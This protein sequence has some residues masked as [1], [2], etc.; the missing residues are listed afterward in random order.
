MCHT[1]A[2]A[3]TLHNFRNMTNVSYRKLLMWSAAVALCDLESWLQLE[4]PWSAG[5][6]FHQV[7]TWL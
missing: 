6:C 3:L 5:S 2:S 4:N 7:T 1:V